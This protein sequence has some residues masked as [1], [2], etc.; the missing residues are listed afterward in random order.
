M[1][2]L[3]VFG[4]FTEFVYE[5]ARLSAIVIGVAEYEFKVA[6]L[7]TTRRDADAGP[8]GAGKVYL[9]VASRLR[10]VAHAIDHASDV[11]HGLA[12]AA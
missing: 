1:R 4:P 12:P 9:D 8:S 6:E 10:D 11:R 5:L 3:S 2:I 7:D